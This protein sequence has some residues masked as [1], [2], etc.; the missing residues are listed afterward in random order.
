MTYKHKADR[1]KRANSEKVMTDIYHVC[2]TLKA[3][4]KYKSNKFKVL[5]D[6]ANVNAY[7]LNKTTTANE[8]TEMK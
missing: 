1:E 4:I 7:L 8:K 6:C 5:G 3:K 2:G